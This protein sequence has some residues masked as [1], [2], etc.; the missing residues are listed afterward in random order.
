[1]FHHRLLLLPFLCT[2]LC[3]PLRQSFSLF[4]KTDFICLSVLNVD[5]SRRTG[6]N[7]ESFPVFLRHTILAGLGCSFFLCALLCISRSD[8]YTFLL[9]TVCMVAACR[10]PKSKKSKTWWKLLY[11]LANTL[12]CPYNRYSYWY[13]YVFV[14]LISHF[15]LAR[16]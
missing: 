16:I 4:M 14:L 1:M 15:Y 7:R 11:L 3:V 13:S 9:T 2:A 5:S 10:S 6:I 12:L 8:L